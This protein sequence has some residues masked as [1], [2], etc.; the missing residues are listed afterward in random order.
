RTSCVVHEG[1]GP[2]VALI[3]D[4]YARSLAPAM[5][6]LAKE[7]D[8][9]LVLSAF[10]GCSWQQGVTTQDP[11]ESGV[12]YCKRAR[13]LY[14]DGGLLAELGVDVTLLVQTPRDWGK[15]HR[16]LRAADGS[17]TDIN[18]LNRR[19]MSATV[20]AIRGQGS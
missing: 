18:K 8:F 3:G 10:G 19:T 2:T 14:Y 9:T 7:H 20:R 15:W 5:V 12:D 6:E 16:N 4:S 1:S 11:V 17:R 13:D